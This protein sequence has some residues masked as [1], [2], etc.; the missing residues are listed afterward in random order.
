MKIYSSLQ[1]A[2]RERM[3]TVL[4]VSL[5]LSNLATIT[6]YIFLRIVFNGFIFSVSEDIAT[7]F[8]I[9]AIGT[10]TGLS[11][12]VLYCVIELTEILMGKKTVYPL[13]PVKRSEETAI[14][15]KMPDE[16]AQIRA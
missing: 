6:I 10:L 8:K 3:I 9:L 15:F 7:V 16:A 11:F 12:F 1:P 4:K 2:D 5:Y 14:E 13:L